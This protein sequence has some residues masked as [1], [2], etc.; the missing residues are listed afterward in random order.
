MT[1][2]TDHLIDALYEQTESFLETAVREWQLLP[3]E[4]LAAP[5][6]PGAWSAAQC[7]EHLNFYGSYY[8]PAIERAI[9][10]GRRQGMQPA[11]AFRSGWLGGYFTRLMAPLADGKLKSKMRAPKNAT[12]QTAPDPVAMLA[13]FISQQETMLRLLEAA[14]AVNLT[15]LKVPISIAPWLRL[16]LG[17]ILM[18]Y[19]AHHQRHVLQI[20]RALATRMEAATSST[21]QGA[22]GKG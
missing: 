6:A 5:P 2:Q 19:T 9:E 14:P 1:Y 17:D 15:R 8:L 13:E 7:L 3:P 12:P 22:S 10:R 21:L 18:F 20:Q 16:R 4:R 11:P